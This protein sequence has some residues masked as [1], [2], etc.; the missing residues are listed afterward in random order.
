M[1]AFTMGHESSN[2]LQCAI[3]YPYDTYM[4]VKP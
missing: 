4:C 3:K 1:D 2:G